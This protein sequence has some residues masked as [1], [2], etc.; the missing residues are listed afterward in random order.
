MFFSF[1]DKVHSCLRE[2]NNQSEVVKISFHST[3]KN[4]TYKQYEEN[5]KEILLINYDI[6]NGVPKSSLLQRLQL[7]GIMSLRMLPSMFK[8]IK[9]LIKWHGLKR[10]TYKDKWNSGLNDSM[11]W[12]F[13]SKTKYNNFRYGQIEKKSKIWKK[14]NNTVAY[15][16]GAFRQRPRLS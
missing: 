1:W 13:Q 14:Y 8:L 10:V 5:S 7:L 2:L 11:A 15:R 4:L 6:V 9:H 12:K 3:D 16:T